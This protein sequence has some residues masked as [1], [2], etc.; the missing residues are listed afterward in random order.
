MV[1]GMKTRAFLAAAAL[2]TVAGC[3]SDEAPTAKKSDPPADSSTDAAAPEFP[4]EWAASIDNPW[5]PLA[6]GAKWVYEKQTPDGT[7][8][9]VITVTKKT[10]TIVGVE[11]TVVREKV[12]E[13]GELIDDTTS[14]YAQDADGNVWNLGENTETTEDGTTETE[15]WEAGVDGATAGIAM[16][17]DPQVGDEYAQMDYP[18]EAEDRSK[19]LSVDES[20]EVPFGSYTEVLQ[21]EDTTP[22][23]PEVVEHKFYAKDIGSIE[24]RQVEGEDETVV[25]VEY[26]QP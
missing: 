24:Q 6:A 9:V 11:A 26:T 2:V 22:L 3:G 8:D 1:S 10:K 21:T 15:G 14:W 16:L 23:E 12:S 13:D 19:V 4:S 5:L 18:G 7:E 17:A 20:V 25:L